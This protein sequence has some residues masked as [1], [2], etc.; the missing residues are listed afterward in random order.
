[1]KKYFTLLLFILPFSLNAD[2]YEG[3]ILYTVG[4]GGF[5]HHAVFFY[6]CWHFYGL[7]NVSLCEQT[8]RAEKK[9]NAFLRAPLMA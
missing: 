3:Y 8:A 9:N 7:P 4:G 1:M 5:Y 6:R 2:V